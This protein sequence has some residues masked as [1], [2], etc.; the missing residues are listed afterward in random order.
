MKN[1]IMQ[2][3]SLCVLVL[4]LSANL[5]LMMHYQ[6]FYKVYNK[7]F[8]YNQKT[9]SDYKTS[10]YMGFTSYYQVIDYP[11]DVDILILGDSLVEG[12]DYSYLFPEYN[13]VCQGIGGDTTE[14][15]LNRL[16]LAEKTG[17]KNIFIQI[18]INDLMHRISLE[19]IE[20]NHKSIVK[21]LKEKM[22]NS[23]LYIVSLFPTTREWEKNAT[24]W[25]MKDDILKVNASL[26]K[27]AKDENVPYI[28]MF[29]VLAQNVDG[30][31]STFGTIG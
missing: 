16:D 13:V 26:E 17:A 7:V 29:S 28:D 20:N 14:G 22:P 9:T 4:S 12:C 24:D 5:A 23:Q 1:K 8:S 27:I 10:P 30:G 25:V 6:V 2:I 15:L 19:T 31:V 3:I 18:G 21:E 11:N